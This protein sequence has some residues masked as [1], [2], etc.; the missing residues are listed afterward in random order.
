M[1]LIIQHLSVEYYRGK[2]VIPAV[3]GVSLALDAGKSLG[4]VGESGSGK[5]TIALA[6]LK[7][8]G[9]HEGKITQGDILFSGK[10][11]L[12]LPQEEMRKIRGNEIGIIFQDPFSSLNP[13]LRIGEQ[14]EETIKIHSEK[15][16]SRSALRERTLD[17]LRSVS[18][19][20]P[21]RI[22]RSYPHQISGGQRQ[23]AMIAMAIANHPKLLI[24]DEPTTALDVTVQKEILELLMKL[25]KEMNMALILITHHLGIVS[26]IT[27]DL[28]VLYG[29]EIV[30]RG[31]TG[32]MLRD[33]H[34]PYTQTL[35]NAVPGTR[36]TREG[37]EDAP[38]DSHA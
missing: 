12:S 19:G 35:L 28:Y 9:E 13:V 8:I 5:S 16:I 10:N 4:I 27:E 24:A 36:R 29:G 32:D 34:H 14:I 30:E 23:R 18:L 2:K 6:I 3:H 33:P 37:G 25:Q 15:P 26:Q 17:S 11:L 38:K 21:E 22:A 7:L 20:E 1:L 31:K